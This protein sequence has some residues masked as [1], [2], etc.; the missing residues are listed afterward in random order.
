MGV[1]AGGF[2][3]AGGGL[4]PA[5]VAP[6]PA[7]SAAKPTAVAPAAN[8]RGRRALKFMEIVPLARKREI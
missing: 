6:G 5:E 3:A 1:V 8:S 2:G 4:A 7:I